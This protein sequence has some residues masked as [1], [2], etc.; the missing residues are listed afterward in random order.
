[1]DL[2]L[3]AGNYRVRVFRGPEYDVA[4]RDLKVAA[5]GEAEVQIPMTRWSHL[6]KAGWYSGE[7]HVHANYGYGEWYN[8]PATILRQAE[9]EDLN[10]CNTVIANSDGEA[11]FDKLAPTGF[12]LL[13]LSPNT[14]AAP[15][16]EAARQ[17][18]VPLQVVDIASDRAREIYGTDLALIRPDQHLAWRG[19]TANATALHLARGVHPS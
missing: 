15:M 17:A 3:P 18:N 4:E 8:T 19:N 10:V 14:D 2:E 5:D 12:T 1:M 11:I 7:N 13:R 16:Q 6:A 9:G